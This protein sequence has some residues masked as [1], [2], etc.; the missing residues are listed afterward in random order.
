MIS[1]RQKISH[2]TSVL[3]ALTKRHFLVFLKNW[4]VVLFTFLVPL[5]ILLIYVLFLR[6]LEVNTI[7][8]IINDTSLVLP[9]LFQLIVLWL[10]IKKEE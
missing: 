7:D 1:F 2:N 9:S 6:P 5:V 4:T 8:S 10:R 3:L